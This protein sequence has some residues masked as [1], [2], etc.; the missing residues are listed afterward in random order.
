MADP[1]AAA[2]R[3]TS[4]D[5]IIEHLRHLGHTVSA[6]D[7]ALMELDHGLQTAAI[8]AVSAPDDVGVQVA[9]LVHDLAHPWDGPGQP[10]HA[11]MGAAA[12]AGVL[13]ER[14]ATLIRSHVPAKRYLVAT[15]PEYAAVL[16]P[17][18]VM[19]LAAQGGPMSPR[20]VAEF[21]T[22]PDLRA[23]VL[24]RQADDGAKVPGA[25]VPGLEHWEAALRQVAAAHASTTAG[26]MAP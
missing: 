12:V 14:V 9:G 26:S 20:E 16:S 21:E 5:E 23:A 18:S 19:T 22:H 4:V 7:G 15:R 2:H 17:D 3:F 24:L 1:R 10:R 6:E 25:E 11:T 13:G 8:L